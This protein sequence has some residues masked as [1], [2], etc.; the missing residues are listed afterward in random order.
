VAAELLLLDH[1]ADI[2][3]ANRWPDASLDATPLYVAAA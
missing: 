1:G 2:D 3:A